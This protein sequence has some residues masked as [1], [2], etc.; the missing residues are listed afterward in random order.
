MDVL[1]KMPV[2][3]EGNY[4]KHVSFSNDLSIVM[5]GKNRQALISFEE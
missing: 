5:D 3:E 4:I 2:I 1:S